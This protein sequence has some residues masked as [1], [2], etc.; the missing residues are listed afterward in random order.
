[1]VP[2]SKD[3]P[4]YL[5]ETTHGISCYTHVVSVLHLNLYCYTIKTTFIFSVWELVLLHDL[6]LSLTTM[7]ID[8]ILQG[9]ESLFRFGL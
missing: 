3:S 9:A 7:T 1:M 2:Y 5:N 6:F 8:Q 4:I